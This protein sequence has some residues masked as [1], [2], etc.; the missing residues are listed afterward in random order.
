MPLD[1]E[2][3]ARL[4]SWLQEKGVRRDCIACGSETWRVGDVVAPPPTPSGGG[5]VV[6]GP[7]FPLA[8]IICEHCG[9][10][11]HFSTVTAGIAT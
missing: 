11:M 3:R 5:T 9:F 2:R 10:V 7:S 1:D 6:G 8:Q 4:E